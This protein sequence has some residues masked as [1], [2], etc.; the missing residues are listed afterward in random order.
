MSVVRVIRHSDCP[1]IAWKNGGGTTREIAVFP[2]GAGIDDFLWR[3]SMARVETAGPFSAF[4]GVNRVLTVLEGKLELRGR[5]F[6]TELDGDS[7]PFAFDGGADVTGSPLH[8]PVLDLN[9]MAR[10][11]QY[12]I[13]VRRVGTG[14]TVICKGTTLLFALARQA[15]G[16][17]VLDYRDCAEIDAPI[18]ATGGALSIYATPRQAG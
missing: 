16:D 18:A 15:V 5:D 12:D 8:G 6:A 4:G 9:A 1:E 11:S 10:R 2:P 3:L 7:L 14:D 13:E 17:V